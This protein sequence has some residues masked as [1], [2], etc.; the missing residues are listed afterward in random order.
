MD[1]H[2]IFL[3]NFMW[4]VI[5]WPYIHKYGKLEQFSMKSLWCSEIGFESCNEIGSA[6]TE[7]PGIGQSFPIFI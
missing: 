7:A 2:Q 4:C 6:L 5:A 3:S 1:K